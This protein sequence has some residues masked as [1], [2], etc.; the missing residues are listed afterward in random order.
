MT[1]DLFLVLYRQELVRNKSLKAG[2]L[3]PAFCLNINIA[4]AFTAIILSFPISLLPK[5]NVILK[6]LLLTRCSFWQSVFF[7]F[8]HN[9]NFAH[10]T[11]DDYL[12]RN[13]K[14][15]VKYLDLITV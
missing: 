11:R 10:N 6:N 13:D 1:F 4:V 5:P 15:V 8:C 3:K 12:L 7:F 9:T 2:E 14:V